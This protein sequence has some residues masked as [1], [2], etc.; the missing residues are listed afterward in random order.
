VHQVVIE[1]VDHVALHGA[2]VQ[3][4]VGRDTRLSNGRTVGVGYCLRLDDR[5]S[6]RPSR[7][8]GAQRTRG[9]GAKSDAER[10]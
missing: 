9:E 4:L 7:P 6:G 5:G 3:L 1:P 8:V 10:R 2:V